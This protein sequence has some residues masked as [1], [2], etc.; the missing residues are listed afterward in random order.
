MGHVE[1]HV[2]SLQPG[3]GVLGLITWRW[4]SRQPS[5]LERLAGEQAGQIGMGLATAEGLH[6]LGVGLQR[7]LHA[8]SDHAQTALLQQL[9]PNQ[10]GDLAAHHTSPDQLDHLAKRHAVVAMVLEG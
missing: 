5:P 6:L 1:R 2:L 3:G 4:L 10:L 9:R 7:R 8:G